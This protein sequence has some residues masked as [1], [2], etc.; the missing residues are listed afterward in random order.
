[1]TQTCIVAKKRTSCQNGQHG[2]PGGIHCFVQCVSRRFYALN[3]FGLATAVNPADK[4]PDRRVGL[5]PKEYPCSS[6]AAWPRRRV[7]KFFPV[8]VALV[9]GSNML[10]KLSP[11]LTLSRGSA[12]TT[13][14]IEERISRS[15]YKEM[16]IFRKSVLLG[17]MGCGFTYGDAYENASGQ[18]TLTYK[19]PLEL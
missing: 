7:S 18:L 13:S 10:V 1:M 8:T 4:R 2:S 16:D 3:K 12:K 5:R 19:M 15:P 6:C 14:A 9:F 11:T 17:S